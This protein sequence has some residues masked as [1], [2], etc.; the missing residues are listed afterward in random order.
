M[1]ASTAKSQHDPVDN[2]AHYT[3]ADNGIECIDAI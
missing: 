2:P 1:S 3:S